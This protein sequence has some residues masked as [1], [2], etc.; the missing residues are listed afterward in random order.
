MK[1]YMNDKLVLDNPTPDEVRIFLKELG[2]LAMTSDTW[3]ESIPDWNEQFAPA[4]IVLS[5]G[6]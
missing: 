2:V 3:A 1:L 5:V 6:E 4:D